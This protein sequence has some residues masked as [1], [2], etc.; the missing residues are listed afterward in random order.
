MT[1]LVVR[2][3]IRFLF[4]VFFQV[5]ILNHINLGGYANPYLYVY[6]ILLLPFATPR[7]LLLV[8]AFALGI[9]IDVFTN[10]PG[11]NAAATVLMAFFRPYVIRAISREPE[12]E[13]GIQPSLK[14]RGFEWF[15]FYSASLVGIHHLALF[16]LEIFRFTEFFQTLLRVVLS[17]LFT[18]AM[19]FL[20]ELLFYPGRMQRR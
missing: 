10:T 2:N 19:I 3:S 4:L 18:L 6:F 20:S 8:L 15:F 13:L 14:G 12:E 17:S 16:Y 7:W 1:N 11:L 9:S 5:L